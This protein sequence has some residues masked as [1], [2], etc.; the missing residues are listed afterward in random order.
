MHQSAHASL[1]RIESQPV[2]AWE[3]LRDRVED[4]RERL[5]MTI[6]IEA[7]KRLEGAR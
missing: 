5:H 4:K 2:S 1:K 7:R 3:A 6:A